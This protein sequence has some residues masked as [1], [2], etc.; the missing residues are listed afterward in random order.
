MNETS[1]PPVARHRNPLRPYVWGGAALL[2]SIPAIAMLFTDEVNWDETDFIVM[3]ALLAFA[4]GVYE[5]GARLSGSRAY[6]AGFALSIV[7]GFLMVWANLAVGFVGEPDNPVN[8]LFFAILLTG[9]IAAPL[10]RFTPMGMARAL[11]ATAIA[12]ALVTLWIALM[13]DFVFVLSGFFIAAWLSAA[14]LF[15]VAAEEQAD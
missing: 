7:A 12:Q 6:R 3:G 1:T 2:L 11:Y 10:G 8:L 9:A 14:H 5:V 4:C 15:R 13:G